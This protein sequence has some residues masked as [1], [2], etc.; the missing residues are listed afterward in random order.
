[1][2]KLF[3][4]LLVPEWRKAIS[5]AGFADGVL[6][7]MRSLCD[8][9]T[10]VIGLSFKSE[11]TRPYYRPVSIYTD[12]IS[13]NNDTRRYEFTSQYGGIDV[14]GATLSDNCAIVG[15]DFERNGRTYTFKKHPSTYGTTTT[16]NGRAVIS[17]I[18]I[19]G[20]L[21]DLYNPLGLPYF[22][23][24]G[25]TERRAIDMAV[26][27]DAPLG[28]TQDIITASFGCKFSENA[29]KDTWT[30]GDMRFGL[31]VNDELIYAPIALT[32]VVFAVGKKVDYSALLQPT[33]YFVA[34]L[35]N[36]TF[37]FSLG[38]NTTAAIPDLLKNYPE[39]VP[40]SSST[41]IGASLLSIL[42]KKGCVFWL[43]PYIKNGINQNALSKYTVNPGKVNLSGVLELSG[44][45][46][47]LRQPSSPQGEYTCTTTSMT[48]INCM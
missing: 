25:E 44:D 33:H 36:G 6:R 2:A 47:S 39:L 24:T 3:D 19:G 32:Q 5:P 46:I 22:G 40:L 37:V 42:V 26:H 7:C 8:R 31:T 20:E 35:V 4:S 18:C 28:I 45:A 15:R 9:I 1:M 38:L 16:E 11:T 34:K 29:L 10:R 23:A 21:S 27:G 12:Q 48:L 43:I 30:E 13:F 41:F 14:F 17:F